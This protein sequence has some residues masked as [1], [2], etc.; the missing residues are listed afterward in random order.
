MSESD[1]P[2]ASSIENASVAAPSYSGAALEWLSALPNEPTR[3]DLTAIDADLAI[4]CVHKLVENG[5]FELTV[6]ANFP[7]GEWL[8]HFY[9]EARNREKVFGTKTSV[10]AIRS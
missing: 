8:H 4:S 2:A 3:A 9:F 6:Q 10:S 5:R 7:A 1:I